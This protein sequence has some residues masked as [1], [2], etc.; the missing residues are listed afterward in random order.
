MS[1]GLSRI[2]LP[3]GD[4]TREAFGRALAELGS[5][6]RIVERT[7]RGWE[8]WF[9]LL[10]SWG[11]EDLGHTEL[12]RRVA[13]A[14][15]LEPPLLL[16][17]PPQQHPSP[18]AVGYDADPGAGERPKAGRDLGRVEKFRQPDDAQD[19]GPRQRRI[20][21]AVGPR[22]GAG[23]GRGSLG[24]RRVAS[25]LD[26]D[27]RLHAGGARLWRRRWETAIAVVAQVALAQNGSLNGF[28]DYVNKAMREWDVPGLAVA[29][30]KGDQVDV[31]ETAV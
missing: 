30:V 25:C 21:D 22:Q 9:E 12:A 24:A 11:A 31:E 20:E 26:R 4:P 23:V 29:I 5:D 19:A 1:F 18:A 3:D 16:G 15:D 10:D 8:E 6:E 2:D 28:D 13:V 17:V 27:H 14:A 7:G